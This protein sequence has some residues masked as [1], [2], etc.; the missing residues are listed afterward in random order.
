MPRTDYY[1]VLGVERT[2]T[3]EE[4]KKAF[5][6]VARETHPD[7]NPG[8]PE[9]ES[10]FKL[11]AEAYEVLSDPEKRRRHDRGDTIDLGDLFGGVGGLD[12]LIRS[13]FG[14]SGLF[15]GRPY[16]QPRGSDILVR[17]DIS[18]EEAAFGSETEI[19]YSTLL[20]C[21]VCMGTGSA[22]GTQPTTCPDCGGAGQVRMAQRS[23]FG[24]VMSV[25]TCPTCQGEGVLIADPCQIC[26][27]SGATADDVA[28]TVE[29]PAGVSSGTRLRLSGRGE[30]GGRAG[31][32]G[33][34]FVE[35]NVL[36]DQRFERRDTDLVHR[37][38][39][40]VVEASL[41][42]QLGVP[43]I[44]GEQELIDVP[45]GTQ[46]GT[47]FELPGKGMTSLGRQG[48]GRMLVIVDV[49]I[50]EELSAEEEGLI[51]RLGDI[52]QSRVDRPASAS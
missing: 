40:D 18:L 19:S 32:P 28:V 52:R 43:T 1:K 3:Q 41:G 45:P 49:L 17:T 46:P 44:D 36:P 29:I 26:S 15:G 50:P 21:T 8:N 20:D 30:S 13:V 22:P 34:L 10:Q 9:A 11:A 25:T 39:V 33:D 12:D 24:T 2:A 47:V 48:R 37:T 7:A 38:S 5:R 16:R 51:R 14:D 27:G 35:V 6:K 31:H 4:I 23:M 42:M